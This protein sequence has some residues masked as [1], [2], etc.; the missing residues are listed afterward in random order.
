MYQPQQQQVPQINQ[1]GP[2]QNTSQYAP[3]YQNRGRRNNRNRGRG[4]DNRYNTQIRGYPYGNMM[5]P[6][7][8]IP[9]FQQQQQHGQ[10]TFSITKKYFNNLNYC[11]THGHDVEDWHNSSTRPDPKRGHQFDAT[12]QNTMNGSRKAAHKVIQVNNQ[13]QSTEP[14]YGGNY[15]PQQNL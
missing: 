7:Q 9:Q 6:P 8:N 15:Y 13:G 14:N 2:T 10:V 11:W 3:Q 5:S 4:R 1:Y 12:N